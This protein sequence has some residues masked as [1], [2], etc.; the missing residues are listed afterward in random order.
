VS[1]KRQTAIF[2]RLAR[3]SAHVVTLTH[4]YPAGHVIPTHYHNRDQLVFASRGVMTVRTNDG[5]WVVP[6]HRAVWIPSRVP[7]KIAMSGDVAM[8]TLYLKP[9]LASSLPRGCCVVHVPPL[10]RELILRACACGQLGRSPAWQMHLVHVIL[11]Q[12]QAIQVAPLQLPFPEDRRAARVAAALAADPAGRRTLSQVCLKSGA[13][14]RTIERLF[15]NE[16]ALTVG[17][18]RQQL[19][20][21]EALQLLGKGAKVTY[22]ALETGYSAPSAFIA[23]FRKALGTTP[24][25]YFKESRDGR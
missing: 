12:L 23:A 15:V 16:T 22:A 4:D 7:H 20:L 13:S 9:R 1:R 24:A 19:R 11:D 5:V 17:K 3:S 14:R 6:A 10:L 21:M 18:W 8:R 25:Q 2:D